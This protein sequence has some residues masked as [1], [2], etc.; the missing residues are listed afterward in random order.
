MFD[1]DPDLVPD[2]SDAAALVSWGLLL[3]V[4]ALAIVGFGR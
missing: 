2:W 1:L 4:I 3:A